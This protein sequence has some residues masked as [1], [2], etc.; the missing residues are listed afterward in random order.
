MPVLKWAYEYTHLGK[1]SRKLKTTYPM[2]IVEYCSQY[3]DV[4]EI[5]TD[6]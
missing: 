4:Y 5:I 1:N 3:N 2:D 6:Q